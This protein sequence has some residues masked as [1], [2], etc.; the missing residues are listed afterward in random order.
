MMVYNDSN[1]KTKE[2]LKFLK[3]K[4]FYAVDFKYLKYFGKDKTIY[5]LT[6]NY[7]L[8]KNFILDGLYFHMKYIENIFNP[9]TTLGYKNMSL[10]TSNTTYF[11]LKEILC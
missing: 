10:D 6:E 5:V 8:S 7:T 4:K 11:Y 3:K 9:T 1:P 2:L